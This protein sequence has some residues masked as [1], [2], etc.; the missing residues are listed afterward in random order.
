MINFIRNIALSVLVVI[1]LTSCGDRDRRLPEI[2]RVER[3]IPYHVVEDGDTVG[4]IATK[5]GMS[6]SDLIK[7]NT[8][9]PP[10]QLY[11][12][13]RLVIILRP[14]G[15]RSS[16]REAEVV[17][18]DDPSA[19][20]TEDVKKQ[21]DE[22]KQDVDADNATIDDIA[23]NGAG[24]LVAQEPTEP[25][26]D[27]IWPVADGKNK[28]SQHFD[29]GGITIAAS[30][31]TPVRA[32]ADG[33]VKI[34]GVPDGEAAAYGVT[35]VLK[36]DSK[37]MLSIYANLDEAMVNKSKKVKKGDI[38]GKV[39]KSGT[40]AKKSQLY[41]EMNDLAGKERRPVDPEKVLP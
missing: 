13:Q 9:K 34:A 36:H 28:I 4:S 2:V 29:D 24:N 5:Y 15:E 18:P 20:K 17:K 23:D 40:I 19:P 10:Y 39:G 14:D 7:L 26:S 3:V 25:T 33:I 8:L 12:G 1:G 30:A 22:K 11:D 21:A 35:I 37:N 6:R 32:I 16:I 27:Y 31:G 41:F 38:I